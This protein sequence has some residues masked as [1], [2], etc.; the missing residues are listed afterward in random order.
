MV[1]L[2]IIGAAGR[3]GKRLIALAADD[4]ALQVVGAVDLYAAEVAGLDAGLSAGTRELGTLVTTDLASS[5]ART[6]VVIDF[7]APDMTQAYLQQALAA[8]VAYVLG[9]TGHS[10]EVK[11]H[12]RTLATS[13]KGRLVMAPNY[14]I[15]VN[16]LFVLVEEAARIL[17]EDY[18]VEIVE[19]HHNKKKDAPSGTAERLGELVAAVRERAYEETTRH[20]RKGL[21]GARVKGEIGMHA[22]RGGDVVGDHTV[23]FAANGDRVEL[24]HRAGSRDTFAAGALRAAKFVAHA[25][26][27]VYD[28]RDVLGLK[29]K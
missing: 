28:M 19:M 15:G 26:P 6:D 8:G 13:A 9:T 29:R 27:G 12:L 16:T 20:G 10:Q 21:V 18:D 3:M 23:M 17:G 5:L 1:R 4:P 2:T 14:S 7:S 11:Q 25:A 24:S 22:L